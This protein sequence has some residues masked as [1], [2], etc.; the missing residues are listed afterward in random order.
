[1]A[2]SPDNATPSGK[3]RHKPSEEVSVVHPRL[4]YRSA[5]GPTQYSVQREKTAHGGPAAGHTENVEG[6]I[7][8]QNLRPDYPF[9]RKRNYC[10]PVFRME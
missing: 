7:N 2:Y 3:T 6:N 9:G 1:M 10:M 5:R 8:L 4:D